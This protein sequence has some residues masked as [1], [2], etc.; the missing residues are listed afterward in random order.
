MAR[1]SGFGVKAVAHTQKNAMP[2]KMKPR[3][4]SP[5]AHS[6][7]IFFQKTKKPLLKPGKTKSR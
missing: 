6:Q 4:N 2:Q 1:G 5:F 7:A 3:E